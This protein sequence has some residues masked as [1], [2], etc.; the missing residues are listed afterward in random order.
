MIETGKRE[1]ISPRT[2]TVL[3]EVLGVTIDW[4]LTGNGKQPRKPSVRRAVAAAVSRKLGTVP[5]AA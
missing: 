3:A 5:R 4:L 1:Q 2:A